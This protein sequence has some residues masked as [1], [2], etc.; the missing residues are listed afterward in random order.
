MRYVIIANGNLDY[1]KRVI[2]AI[3]NA[4]FI[5]CADGGARH[6]K[7]LGITPD[8]MLGDFDS[9][10]DKDRI[11][12]EN[13]HVRFICFPEKKDYTDTELCVRWAVKNG[14]TQITLMG[15]TGTRL[16]HTMAN[17]FLL[18]M[19]AEK[20]IPAKIMDTNNEIYLVTSKLM[21]QGCPGDIVSIIPA[22]DTVQGVTLKGFKYPLENA[23]L[24]MGTSRGISNVLQDT[25]AIVKVDRGVLIVTKSWD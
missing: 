20:K 15:V 18:R 23:G 5:I 12:F 10:Q 14:A 9:I 11:F 16:D 13:S 6:M 21:L 17:I 7:A 8:I 3:K 22:T 25:T 24:E 1:S 19:L 4:D 2:G